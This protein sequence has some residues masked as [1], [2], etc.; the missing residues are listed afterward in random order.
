[1]TSNS[2]AK[3]Q[4]EYYDTEWKK[5]R[6]KGESGDKMIR[7]NAILF[8]L[9]QFKLPRNPQILDAGCGLGRVS[10]ELSKFGKVTG[11]D[12]SKKTVEDNKKLY[13]HILFVP[14]NI[15]DSNPP[16]MKNYYDLVVSSEVIEHIPYNK[17]KKFIK[18]I[19]KFI[20]NDGYLIITTPN[21]QTTDRLELYGDQPI[22]DF[23]TVDELHVLLRKHFIIL[24]TYNAY[25]LPTNKILR[26]GVEIMI[27]VCFPF[28][29]RFIESRKRESRD[30][31]YTICICKKP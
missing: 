3:K 21:K 14:G 6:R 31:I 9:K 22:E 17:Q 24:E 26:I 28:Y 18:N 25:F 12:I 15:L 20:S 11:I 10:N 5:Y 16:I 4:E 27:K 30:G 7:R 13:P 1:M 2:Y 23:L 19:R 8:C 29:L